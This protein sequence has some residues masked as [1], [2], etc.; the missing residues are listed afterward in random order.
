MPIDSFARTLA[1]QGQQFCSD[2]ASNFTGKGA[3]MIG[4]AGGGTVEDVLSSFRGFATVTALRNAS[5]APFKDGDNVST[6][7]ATNALDT[8]VGGTWR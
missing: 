7:S 3:S 8:K 4:V 2:V 6:A 5:T 1:L